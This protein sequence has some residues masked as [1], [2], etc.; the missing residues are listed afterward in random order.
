MILF[1]LRAMFHSRILFLKHYLGKI[2]KEEL[3]GNYSVVSYPFC[4]ISFHLFSAL[5]KGTQVLI[6]VQTDTPL[7]KY[8]LQRYSKKGSIQ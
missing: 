5:F 6:G 8:H 3:R 1:G 4:L 2:I 7:T